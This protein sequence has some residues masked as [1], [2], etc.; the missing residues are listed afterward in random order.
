MR[1]DERVCRRGG[2]ERGQCRAVTTARVGRSV[3]NLLADSSL[4]FYAIYRLTWL[5][6]MIFGPVVN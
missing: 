4:T 3:R 1:D 2:R 6:L 5:G